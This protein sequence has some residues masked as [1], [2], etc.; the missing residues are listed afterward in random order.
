M[1][2]SV[3][4]FHNTGK[5]SPKEPGPDVCGESPGPA[6][7]GEGPHSIPLALPGPVQKLYL[8]SPLWV[9]ETR[10]LDA[11]ANPGS[12][13]AVTSAGPAAAQPGSDSA[14]RALR[15]PAR[16]LDPPLRIPKG[17]SRTP[18]AALLIFKH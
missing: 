3:L 12:S 1:V 14:A 9:Q 13:S 4:V 8:P 6:A 5:C 11:P 17:N 18:A 7:E 15:I 2:F 16:L 10:V